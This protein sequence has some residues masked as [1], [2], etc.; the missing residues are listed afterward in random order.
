MRDMVSFSLRY[1]YVLRYINVIGGPSRQE[2]NKEY[3][4]FCQVFCMVKTNKKNLLEVALVGEI[5]HTSMHPSYTT[6]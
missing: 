1:W 4:I 3:E 6:T 2:S 5:T